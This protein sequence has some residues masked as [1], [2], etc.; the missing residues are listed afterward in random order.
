MTAVHAD[1]GGVVTIQVDHVDD[2]AARCPREYQDLVE[3]TAFVNWRRIE[4]GSAPVLA[5]SFY[6]RA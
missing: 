2:F 1:P 5:L 6:R 3:C 4:R